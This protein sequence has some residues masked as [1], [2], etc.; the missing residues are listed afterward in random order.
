MTSGWK[1][2]IPLSLGW[3][4]IVAGFLVD[5]W[6]GLGIAVAVVALGPPGAGLR[7]RPGGGAEQAVLPRCAGGWC[8]ARGARPGDPAPADG[9]DGAAPVRGRRR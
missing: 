5:G 3:L 4:L 2:L 6:W 1:Y 8:G 7:R 9:P